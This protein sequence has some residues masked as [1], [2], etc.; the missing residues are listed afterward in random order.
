MPPGPATFCALGAILAD[1]KRDYVR[2]R[3]LRF[4]DGPPVAAELASIFRA[5]EESAS[6][7]IRSEGDILGEVVFDASLDLRYA[8]Q[9]FD[10]QVAIPERLRKEPDLEAITELFHREHER[11]YSFRDPESSVEVSTERVRVT[12]RIPALELP[13]IPDRGPAEPIDS[14]RVYVGGRD[15]DVPV[16]A[17]RALGRGASIPGP[18]VIEQEDCTVW[19]LP[20]WNAA[21]HRSGSILIRRSDGA[22]G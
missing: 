2:S 6:S 5:L 22:G 19:V 11:I 16:H 4:A 18:A 8:G 12:G 20:G 17:R 13:P 21:V 3:R 1:V 10:L 15:L 14:R 9:A 7:W